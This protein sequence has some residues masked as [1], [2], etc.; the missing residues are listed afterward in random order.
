MLDIA[1]QAIRLRF[2]VFYTKGII[3]YLSDCFSGCLSIMTTLNEY[4]LPEDIVQLKSK[5]AFSGRNE[6]FAL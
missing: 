2:K 6:K 4:F 5:N 3:V 1:L